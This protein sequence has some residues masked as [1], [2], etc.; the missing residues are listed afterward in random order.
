[1]RG[2]PGVG[3]KFCA[4]LLVL[5]IEYMFSQIESSVIEN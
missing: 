4:F 1:M 3:Y 2:W 5:I